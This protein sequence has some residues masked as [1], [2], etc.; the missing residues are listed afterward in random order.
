MST[1][2]VTLKGNPLTL[3]GPELTVG[4]TAPVATLKKNLVEDISLSEFS[5]NVP[6]GTFRQYSSKALKPI[7]TTTALCTIT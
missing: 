6:C 7:S 5:G 2:T 3:E 1:R 4:Q